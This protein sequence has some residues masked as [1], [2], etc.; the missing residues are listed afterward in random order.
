M[1]RNTISIDVP[2][3]G[4]D[5]RKD[6]QAIPQSLADLAEHG[7]IA[8]MVI[9]ACNHTISVT[10]TSSST[11]FT[12][13]E[14][15]ASNPLHESAFSVTCNTGEDLAK[16]LNAYYQ[17]KAKDTGNHN[18]SATVFSRDANLESFPSVD[19]I[20][21]VQ[22]IW[23][24]VD[25]T[26]PLLKTLL[27]GV[28]ACLHL[29]LSGIDQNQLNSLLG[30]LRQIMHSDDLMYVRAAVANCTCLS[31]LYTNQRDRLVYVLHSCGLT[32]DGHNICKFIPTSESR[33]KLARAESIV[34]KLVHRVSSDNLNAIPGSRAIADNVNEEGGMEPQVTEP[35]V[36][37]EEESVAGAAAAVAGEGELEP[38]ALEDDDMGSSLS[39]EVD[40]YLG[41][42]EFN[43]GVD[44]GRISSLSVKV[45]SILARVAKVLDDNGSGTKSL[46]QSII[47][48]EGD[49]DSDDNNLMTALDEGVERTLLSLS[50]DSM[51]SLNGSI[52][53]VRLLI[54][55]CIHSL[56]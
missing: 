48:Q 10:K 2:T 1:T 42:I 49:S 32:M 28:D 5:I 15:L 22:G 55:E 30:V 56:P 6:I 33:V 18:W 7:K 13:V 27:G 29:A 4:L 14:T 51:Y 26:S 34:S 16:V 47:R 38:A 35:A 44:L 3:F 31:D 45:L 39:S 40:A 12:V 52:R 46:I 41:T 23:E 54:R 9:T 25:S 36:L 17:D 20:G 11:G 21:L 53:K 50:P 8:S 19:S 24:G 37:P 43:H